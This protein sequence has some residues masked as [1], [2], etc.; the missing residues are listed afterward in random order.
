MAED[1]AV[2][3]DLFPFRIN[4][5]S[6]EQWEFNLT[7]TNRGSKSMKLSLQIEL[8]RQV[9]FSKVGLQMQY[10]KR[11]DN[12]KAG[13]TITLKEPIFLSS[14]AE[15]GNYSGWIKIA[16]HYGDYG[17]EMQTKKREILF[18]IMP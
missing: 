14:Q 15:V 18:R 12:F 4:L 16:E 3:S 1:I 17:Y 5:K 6:K 11:F 13:D 7:I 8:P 10:E 2:T 9:T